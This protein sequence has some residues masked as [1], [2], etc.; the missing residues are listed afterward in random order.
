VI[1]SSDSP[2]GAL[3]LVGSGEYTD[4]MLEI[5]TELI[6]SGIQNGKRGGYIQIATAAGEESES[7]IE[8]WKDLGRAQAK[9]IGVPWKFI[10]VFNSSH[11]T[12]TD[13]IRDI[14]DASLI[15]FSGGNPVHLV[16]TFHKSEL[17][18]AIKKEFSTGSSLG[19]CSAGAMAM[20]GEVSISWRRIKSSHEGFGILPKFKI[21][22][23]YDRYFGKIPSPLRKLIT[24][25][26]ADQY[27]VGIDENTALI[28]NS[29]KWQVK[30]FGG[31]H[32]LNNFPDFEKNRFITGENLEF[33]P[34][35]K[36]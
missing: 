36:Y 12:N 16:E 28:W 32:I 31:V 4:A 19:G 34:T 24:N 20:A 8:Y 27:S 30:G 29:G 10:P 2:K 9:K 21:F 26:D 6:E 22:P 1:L 14:E 5:E 15:Y 23:H 13:Y 11:I 18:A 17:L 33:L 3:A 35:P 7:S 25:V